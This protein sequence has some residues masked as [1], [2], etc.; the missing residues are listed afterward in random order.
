MNSDYRI[1]LVKY[2][3]TDGNTKAN[4]LVPQ[5]V[6]NV[7]FIAIASFL[8]ET[9]KQLY[10]KRFENLYT[11][12]DALDSDLTPECPADAPGWHKTSE[13]NHEPA[14]TALTAIRE[15]LAK[16]T[17]GE[18]VENTTDDGFD[19]IEVPSKQMDY[20][21]WVVCG[22]G[23]L[24]ET[25]PEDHY[26]ADFIAHAPADI[27]MLL[28]EVDRLTAALADAQRDNAEL[29]HPATD[30]AGRPLD[31]DAMAA[32]PEIQRHLAETSDAAPS[33]TPSENLVTCPTCKAQFGGR[34]CWRC[35][36][37]SLAIPGDPDWTPTDYSERNPQPPSSVQLRVTDKGQGE[38][39][40]SSD[41]ELALVNQP[42]SSGTA[43]AVRLTKGMARLLRWFR[44]NQNSKPISSSELS[45]GE[46]QVLVRCLRERLV[47][48][49]SANYKVGYGLTETGENALN[50]HDGEAKL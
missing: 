19:Q 32:D 15:R 11:F 44:A 31:L 30:S 16:I 1:Y 22:I 17:P 41:T 4:I 25:D 8:E 37:T 20:G 2:D 10:S 49:V 40:L 24:E 14:V 7:G 29:R 36:W 42:P 48:Q 21:P 5:S 12:Y 28:A 9:G 13:H 50:V 23:D 47:S 18:W 38:S 45:R 27:A 3:L 46:N 33:V 26:N 39:T 34:K 43:K 35:G 6:I